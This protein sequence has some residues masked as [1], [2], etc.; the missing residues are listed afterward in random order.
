[1]RYTK[2]RTEDPSSFKEILSLIK[3]KTIKNLIDVGNQIQL[4]LSDDYLLRI[5]S[6]EVNLLITKNLP[7]KK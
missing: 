6:T 7:D 5:S 4:Q 1:M 2:N 3:G